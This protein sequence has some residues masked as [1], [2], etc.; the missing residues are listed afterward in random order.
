MNLDLNFYFAD[1]HHAETVLLL[2]GFMS[3]HKSMESIG[4]EL[5]DSY[6][7][8][9]VDLPGFGRSYSMEYDYDM[10]T[11]SFGITE[12]LEQLSL[13]RVHALGYSMGGRIALSFGALYPHK[14]HSLILESASPG[15]D[16][17]DEKEKRQETDKNR[18]GKI[19]EN[20]QKFLDD[21]ENMGLFSSQQNLSD[22]AFRQQREMREAQ[23]PEEIADSLLKYGTG[24]QPSYWSALQNMKMPVLLIVGALDQKFV[25]INKK[26]VK[27]LDNAELKIV[28]N[29]GHNIHLESAGKFDIIIKEFLN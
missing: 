15:L 29:A 25:D 3:D 17:N 28:D 8:L 13:D 12:I 19:T 11:I 24:V 21:W 9:Y 5:S 6:N 22:E 2:H 4:E 7:I 1:N 27:S 26:M 16:D 23:R 10:E 18:A 20:Y 14:V